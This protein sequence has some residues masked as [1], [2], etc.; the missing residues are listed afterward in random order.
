[1]AAV[2]TTETGTIDEK[3]FNVVY[4]EQA[5]KW[6]VSWK[7]HGDEAP[8]WLKNSVSE[9]SIPCVAR[10]EYENELCQWIQDG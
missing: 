8:P 10:Q 2:V 9:Y 1:M 5:N 7:W 3:D 6:I 4:D